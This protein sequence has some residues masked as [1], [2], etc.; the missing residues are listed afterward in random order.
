MT[1]PATRR[2]RIAELRVLA[3]LLDIHPELTLPVIR[4]YDSGATLQLHEV[5]GDEQQRVRGVRRYARAVG[6]DVTVENTRS[7]TGTVQTTFT[8]LGVTFRVWTAVDDPTRYQVQFAA[9]GGAR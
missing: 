7:A 4:L 8:Y 1:R 9:A 5:Q 3:Q 6:A 2:H